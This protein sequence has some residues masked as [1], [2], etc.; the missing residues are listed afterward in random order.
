M[1]TRSNNTVPEALQDILQKVAQMQAL[2]DA[3][4][5]MDQIKGLQDHVLEIL[6]APIDQMAAGPMTSAQP[7]GPMGVDQMMSMLPPP[8]PAG[9]DQLGGLQGRP[10]MPNPDEL[11]R[12]VRLMKQ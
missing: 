5:F 8:G 10:E 6:H 12:A 3:P 7:T 9:P 2:P 4:Q 1:A 11:R